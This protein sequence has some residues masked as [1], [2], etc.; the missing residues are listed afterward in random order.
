MSDPSPDNAFDISGQKDR[1]AIDLDVWRSGEYLPA[2]AGQA[3]ARAGGA[4]AV[5]AWRSLPAGTSRCTGCTRCPVAK[6]RRCR[7]PSAR[8]IRSAI[9]GAEELAAV[10]SDAVEP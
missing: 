5:L 7:W 2:I 6:V 9:S 3:F 8:R 1:S 10:K 4:R